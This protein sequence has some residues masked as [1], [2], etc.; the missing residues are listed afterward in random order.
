MKYLDNAVLDELFEALGEELYEITTFFLDQLDDQVAGISQCFADGD[1]QALSRQA[2]ALKGSAA[3]MGATELSEI[4]AKLERLARSGDQAAV[5]PL[6][7]SLPDIA[8]HTISAF[9][10]SK[11][12]GSK[13]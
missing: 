1:L 9:R 10:A 3:N 4:A 2:H 7:N 11:Y 13:A 6:M 12:L 8:A 5:A